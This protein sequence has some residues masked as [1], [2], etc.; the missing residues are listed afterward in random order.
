VIFN[1]AQ[2]EVLQLYSHADVEFDHFKQ[3]PKED[4]FE[5]I[6]CLNSLFFSR[7][8]QDVLKKGSQ[9]RFNTKLVS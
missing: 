9:D 1:S 8:D 6:F 2:S 4:I 3:H 7:D 5:C